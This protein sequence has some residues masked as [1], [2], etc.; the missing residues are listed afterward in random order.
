MADNLHQD[1]CYTC[2]LGDA[3]ILSYLTIQVPLLWLGWS[4][5]GEAIP[6]QF[7]GYLTVTII[8]RLIV[9]LLLYT[10]PVIRL[11][12][13]VY[14]DDLILS[15]LQKSRQDH[16]IFLSSVAKLLLCTCNYSF[17]F[18]LRANQ[19]TQSGIPFTPQIFFR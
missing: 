18:R 2:I 11:R 19:R 12:S 3:T 17:A 15:W 14:T 9:S 5:R 6:T 8:N 1:G 4:G 10:T 7:L 13:R 16:S